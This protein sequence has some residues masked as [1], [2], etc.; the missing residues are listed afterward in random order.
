MIT[1]ATYSIVKQKAGIISFVPR[2]PSLHGNS[3]PDQCLCFRCIDN[4]VP[5]PYESLVSYLRI[6]GFCD[7]TRVVSYLF[8]N[9]K[10]RFSLDIAQ[11][12][13]ARY[14]LA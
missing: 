6:Y 1:F 12:N 10:Y 3:T 5:Q 11:Y 2:K 9:P 14:F 8:R 13:M 4:T 7:G